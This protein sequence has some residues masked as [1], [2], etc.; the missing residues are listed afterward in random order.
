M[1]A[2]RADRLRNV[3]G[4]R[5]RHHEDDMRGRF[6][7]RF[8]QSIESGVG[9]L[10]RFV[11]NVDLEPVSSRAISR[12][13]AQ[14]ANFINPSICGRVNLNHVNRVSCANLDA[15]V[16]HS[17]RLCNR[18]IGRP[19]V[20]RHG[21]NTCDRRLADPTMPAEDVTVGSSALLNGILKCA[22]DVVLPDYVGEL[23]W[24]VFAGEN[25]IAHEG[26]EAQL[27]VSQGWLPAQV[28]ETCKTLVAARAF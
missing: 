2:T 13:L 23:L 8:Q 7:Q 21:Q 5:G 25:L 28:V 10:V 14:L 11:E 16:A 18:F 17:A 15:G 20:Q 22:G 6:L 1:L 9:N 27:Y 4:L 19:A 3:L 24:T 12:S 26:D